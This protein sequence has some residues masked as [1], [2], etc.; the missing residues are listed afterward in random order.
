MWVHFNSCLLILL[1]CDN[2]DE[3]YT[4]DSDVN[5]DYVTLSEYINHT[6]VMRHVLSCTL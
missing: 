6:Y 4:F 2:G 1:A 5:D 3:K